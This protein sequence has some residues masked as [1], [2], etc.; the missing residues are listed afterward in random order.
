MIVTDSNVKKVSVSEVMFY[1]DQYYSRLI[2]SSLS[3]SF[4][5]SFT[6][7]L[8]C[9]FIHSDWFAMGITLHELLTGRRPFEISR[10]QRF[11]KHQPQQSSSSIIVNDYEHG[12]NDEG[13]EAEEDDLWLDYL[14]GYLNKYDYIDACGVVIDKA[15]R[16]KN[17]NKNKNHNDKKV[18]AADGDSEANVHNSDFG[19]Y[20]KLPSST[21]S[22]SAVVAGGGYGYG[23]IHT[24]QQNARHHHQQQQQYYSSYQSKHVVKTRENCNNN[25]RNNRIHRYNIN[26]DGCGSSSVDKVSNTPVDIHQKPP[27]AATTSTTTSNTSST[28]PLFI[29]KACKDFV[30]ALMTINVS[31][32]GMV[33][34]VLIL[35]LC[36]LLCH[37]F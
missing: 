23:G 12:Q 36:C 3:H 10:L 5:P 7:S 24:Q 8:T 22:S 25:K 4:P 9:A 6:H 14:Y 2:H 26:G 32:C 19:Y 13:E 30:Q 28:P 37:I 29:S 1:D 21:S 35:F 11:R 17:D 18:M 31:K 15:E 34:Y 33:Q 16:G 20:R 27:S